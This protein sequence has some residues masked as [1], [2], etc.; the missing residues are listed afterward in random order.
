MERSLATKETDGTALEQLEAFRRRL[1]AFR[2]QEAALATANPEAR[3]ELLKEIED[4]QSLQVQHV[5]EF[6]V[7]TEQAMTD[8]TQQMNDLKAKLE[9]T[10]REQAVAEEDRDRIT[11]AYKALRDR[12]VQ[13]PQQLQ[14][15]G[16]HG[17][18][19]QTGPPS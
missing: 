8:L 14:Q 9:K 10:Q 13:N 19:S 7:H 6:A 2:E 12:S 3:D 16:S 5:A 18:Q 4:V 1:Q 17:N 11:E 15:D